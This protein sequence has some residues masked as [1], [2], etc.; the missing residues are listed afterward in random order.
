MSQNLTF[1]FFL[2]P[3]L[4]HVT[5]SDLLLFS[6]PPLLAPSLYHVTRSYL[7][8]FSATPHPPPL[9]NILCH[10]ILS[11]SFFTPPPPPLANTDTSYDNYQVWYHKEHIISLS[12]IHLELSINCVSSVHLIKSVCKRFTFVCLVKAASLRVRSL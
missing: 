11:L 2:P 1:Y 9:Y 3:P 10:K 8:L 4:Y 7:L 5:R 12:A 6:T